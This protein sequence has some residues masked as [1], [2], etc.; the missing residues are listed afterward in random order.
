MV[1]LRGKRSA[2]PDGIHYRCNC[3]S[4]W[5]LSGCAVPHR[6]WPLRKVL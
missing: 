5:R 3:K 2:I 6:A 1:G 4:Q